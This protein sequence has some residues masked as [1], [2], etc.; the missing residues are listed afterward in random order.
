MVGFILETRCRRMETCFNE[1]V[2]VRS[3]P[4][5]GGCILLASLD[6]SHYWAR[7]IHTELNPSETGSESN[8]WW[9]REKMEVHVVTVALLEA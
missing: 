5:R 4:W 9:L 8:C 6:T 1:R 7:I 3:S 2:L